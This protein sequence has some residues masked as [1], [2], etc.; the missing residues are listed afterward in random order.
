[1]EKDGI[2]WA[3]FQGGNGMARS[4]RNVGYLLLSIY[5]ILAGLGL[6]IGLSF[7]YFGVIQGILALLAGIF[8]LIGR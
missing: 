4:P 3:F 8:I 1:M 7:A 2:L 5:L 6:L